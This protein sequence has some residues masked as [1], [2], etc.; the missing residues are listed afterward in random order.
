MLR[1]GTGGMDT[2]PVGCLEPVKKNTQ[3][4]KQPRD[5]LRRQIHA[6]FGT[7]F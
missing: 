6:Q 4:K 5:G 3:P 1:L 2:K 7:V